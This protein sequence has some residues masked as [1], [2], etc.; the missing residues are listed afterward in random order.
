MNFAAHIG[1]IVI[2]LLVTLTLKAGPFPQDQIP[3]KGPLIV[4]FNHVNLVDGP[5]LLNRLSNR[6]VAIMAKIETWKNP[7]F[8]TVLDGWDGISIRRGEADLEAFRKA[9]KVLA[10]GKIL[11]ISPEGTRSEYSGLGPGHAGVVLLAARSGAPIQAVGLYQHRGFWSRVYRG[12]KRVPISFSVGK[13]FKL[14]LNGA[15]LSKD[16]RQQA[17]D[18]IM[19]QLAAILPPEYRGVYNDLSQATQKYIVPL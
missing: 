16:V 13:P 19:Y 11:I 17:A 15:A 12:F 5:I 6:P 14:E 9:Q 1:N 7:F 18:E 8:A 3:E 2:H 10:D 4:I